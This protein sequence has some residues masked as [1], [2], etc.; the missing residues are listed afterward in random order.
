MCFFLSFMLDKIGDNCLCFHHIFSSDVL[1]CKI[2][3]CIKLCKAKDGNKNQIVGQADCKDI[4]LLEHK[5]QCIW[6]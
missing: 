3:L 2:C 6:W 5:L 1:Q 4:Q